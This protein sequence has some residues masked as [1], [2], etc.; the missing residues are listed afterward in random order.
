MEPKTYSRLSYKERVKIETLLV[1]QKTHSF[2]S[3]LLNR[4]RSTVSREIKQWIRYPTDTY[5]AD[6]ANFAA[7]NNYL[8]KRNLDKISQ[9]YSLRRYVYIGLLDNLS[10]ELIAG[11][12][13]NDFPGNSIMTISHEAIYAHIY[14]HPQAKLNRKLIKLLLHSK[15]YRRRP[16]CYKSTRGRIKD[17]VSIDERPEDVNT[18]KEVGHWEGDLMIGAKQSSAIGTLVERKTRYTHIVKLT[19][20]KSETVTKA[21]KKKLNMMDSIFRKTMTYDNGMEM[22]NHL[23]FTQETGMPVYFAHPYSSWERGTNENTN[24]LIRRF[25]PKGTNFNDVS[26]EQLQ[27]IEDKLNNRPRKVLGFKTPLEMKNLEINNNR[28]FS[29]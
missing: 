2:I 7:E 21:F 26:E 17:A 10:P 1:E 29:G 12:I 6:I 23:W 22:A 15:P 28:L 20:R 3:K 13:K 24:G 16:K 25:L 9:H 11:R 27:I 5:S 8:H 14:K 4:S 19:D 18:R